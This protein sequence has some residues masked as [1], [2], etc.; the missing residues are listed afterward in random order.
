LI[1]DHSPI[2][3]GLTSTSRAKSLSMRSRQHRAGGL[4][5][6]CRMGAWVA[7]ALILGIGL[8]ARG[9]QG[10]AASRKVGDVPTGGPTTPA[11]ARPQSR[12]LRILPPSAEIGDDIVM[13]IADLPGWVSANNLDP[14]QLVLYADGQAL[15]GIKPRWIPSKPNELQFTL[16]QSADTSEIWSE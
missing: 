5:K 15:T 14:K 13:E 11:P 7:T 4:R 6:M 12:I 8:E 1:S 10:E 16:S 9:A 2:F 3:I